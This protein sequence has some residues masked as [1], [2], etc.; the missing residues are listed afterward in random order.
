ME[1]THIKTHIAYKVY[2]VVLVSVFFCAV[3]IGAYE[4]Q[5][6][7]KILRRDIG[8]SLK[9]IAQTAA[10]SIEGEKLLSIESP[11]DAGYN[12]IKSYLVEVK[13]QSH[14]ITHFLNRVYTEKNGV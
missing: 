9:K 7:K 10:I 8:T 5:S 6:N 3:V 1:P 14:L 13:K 4:Y 2:A 12:E 11:E